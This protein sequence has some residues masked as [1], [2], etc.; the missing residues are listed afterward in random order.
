MVTLAAEQARAAGCDWLHVDFEDHLK[1]FYYDACGFAPTD[2][3]LIN[4]KAL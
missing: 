4:L 2:G 3:G 1:P